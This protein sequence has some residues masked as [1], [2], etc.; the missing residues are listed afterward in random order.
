MVK[1]LSLQYMYLIPMVISAWL[2]LRVFKRNWAWSFKVFSVLLLLT[3]L[4]EFFAIWWKLDLYT[5]AYWDYSSSNLWIYNAFVSVRHLLLLG[6]FYG[7]MRTERERNWVK[8]SVPPFIIFGI[9][10]YAF[11]QTPHLVNTYS[12]VLANAITILL[13]IY[14]FRMVLLHKEIINLTKS[15]EVWIAL[16]TFLYYSGT[17]PFFIAFNYF[18]TEKPSIA[19]SYLVINDVLNLV[20]Y[21]TYA[22]AFLCKPHFLK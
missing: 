14:F 18:I 11:I 10:N 16:G 15:A 3:C 21:T 6:W 12:I 5:T 17:L 2:S 9:I 4:V 7:F 13:A 22:I 8:W 19:S 1:L 20:M